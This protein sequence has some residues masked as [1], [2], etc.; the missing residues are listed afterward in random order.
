MFGLFCYL[1]RCAEAWT[2]AEARQVLP[3]LSSLTLKKSGSHGIVSGELDT[4]LS[5]LFPLKNNYITVIVSIFT[6]YY[7]HSPLLKCD[8]SK[9]A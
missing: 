6:I 3:E 1:L 5:I 9:Q 2:R 4:A 7:H 8:C